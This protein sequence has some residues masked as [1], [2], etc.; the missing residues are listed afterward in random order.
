MGYTHCYREKASSPAHQP[1]DDEREFVAE[2]E[3]HL[4]R[5]AGIAQQ[6][7]VHDWERISGS[8]DAALGARLLLSVLAARVLALDAH[9]LRRAGGRRV[10][11]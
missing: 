7:H 8:D 6:V 1:L 2:R 10:G 4:E 3:Q 9:P 11:W 5:A